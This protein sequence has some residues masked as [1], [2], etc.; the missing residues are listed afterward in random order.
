ME[1]LIM[2]NREIDRLKT[3]QKTIDGTLTWPQAAEILSL[4][5]RQIG[6]LCAKVRSRGNHGII[7]GLRGHP[8][9]HKLTQGLIDKAIELIKR[10]YHDFGHTFA[11]EQLVDKDS[12]Y[13]INRQADIEEELRDEMPLTQFTRA[14]GDLGVD[15]IFANSPQAKGRVERGFKTHQDRLVKELRLANISDMAA[16][17]EFLEK[18]YIPKHNA[19]FA[20]EPAST[21]NAHRQLL[22]THNLEEILC[23]KTIRT[24]AN[25][26]TLRYDNRY[27]QILSQ[28]GVRIRAGSKVIIE[29]RLDTT[30]HM[31]FKDTYLCY[32]V[33]DKPPYRGY[34]AR[35]P[36]LLKEIMKPPKGTC[37]PDKNHPWRKFKFTKKYLG[38]QTQETYYT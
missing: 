15:M 29:E 26:Y 35:N 31:K 12:I 21:V 27:F 10:H 9:N 34:Y 17:N 33:I 25:D 23:V 7:H 13:K 20:L 19:K 4:S 18:V 28:D 32:K 14:M 38:K 5:Q 30:L 8:S 3:I 1:C 16:G 11:N 6:R 24:L 2:S 22:K 36:S 37:V